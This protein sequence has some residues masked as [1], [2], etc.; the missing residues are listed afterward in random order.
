MLTLKNDFHNSS[1]T[2]RVTDGFIS[3]RGWERAR[4]LLC[5]I[6]DCKCGG[7]RGENGGRRF[8]H[9]P[10]G[11]I[12][13]TE[14]ANQTAHFAIVPASN[15]TDLYAAGGGPETNQFNTEAEAE[16]ALEN[17]VSTCGGDW[18]ITEVR[19]RR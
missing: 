10:D 6:R 14:R 1:A 17:L 9:Y 4:K 19:S 8:Q 13:V 16:A 3:A 11:R 15:P 12:E 18:E 5:G 7:I 2:V